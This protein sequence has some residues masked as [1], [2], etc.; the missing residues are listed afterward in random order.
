MKAWQKNLSI[1]TALISTLGILFFPCM[2]AM[3]MRGNPKMTQ[4]HPEDS[5]DRVQAL[6]ICLVVCFIMLANSLIYLWLGSKFDRERAR[7]EEEEEI[8]RLNEG[9]EP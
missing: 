8:A 2:V 5:A 9:I 4:K 7:R 1:M 3:Q 6:M